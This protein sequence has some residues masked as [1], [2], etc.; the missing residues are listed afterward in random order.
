[1]FHY[2]VNSHETCSP[3]FIAIFCW[4]SLSHLYRLLTQSS[5]ILLLPNNASK[6]LNIEWV[7]LHPQIAVIELNQLWA[8]IGAELPIVVKQDKHFNPFTG[9]NKCVV[10]H[11]PQVCVQ[12]WLTQLHLAFQ[13]LI[14][15]FSLVILLFCFLTFFKLLVGMRHLPTFNPDGI[16]PSKCQLFTILF[17]V[18]DINRHL[19]EETESDNHIWRGA[20]AA[21]CMIKSQHYLVGGATGSLSL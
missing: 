15:L 11:T 6:K 12:I 1:M 9:C 3:S 5:S 17:V 16:K 8:W 14:L 21:T 20:D 13:D 19:I 18:P 7:R 2:A 4:Y 10:A